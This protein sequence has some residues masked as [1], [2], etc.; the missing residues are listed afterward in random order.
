MAGF[1]CRLPTISKA[2]T[3]GMP[4]ASMVANWRANTAM[5]PG[6]TL[7]PLRLALLADAGRGDALAAQFHGAPTHPAPGSCP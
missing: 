7:P 2:C 1:H 6:L 5:S 3:M 4:E